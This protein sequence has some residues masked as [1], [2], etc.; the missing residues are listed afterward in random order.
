VW[1]QTNDVAEHEQVPPKF[2]EE[3]FVQLRHHGIIESRRGAQGGHRFLRD[4][5]T[6]SWPT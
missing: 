1:L 2:L 5:A 4:P 3:I 6:V